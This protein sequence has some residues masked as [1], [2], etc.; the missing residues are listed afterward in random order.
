MLF[1][2]SSFC[3]EPEFTFCI[4]WRC[5]GFRG[6]AI[7]APPPPP[8]LDWLCFNA[9][10]PRNGA[11]ALFRLSVRPSVWEFRYRQKSQEPLVD[12]YHT[13]PKDAPWRVDELN[14]FGQDPLKVKVNELGLNMLFYLVTVISG[15]LLGGF[16]SYLAQMCTMMSRWTD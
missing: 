7:G 1:H 6:G 9:S 12:F 4:E 10:D 2:V 13:W 11:G 16:L 5:G 14:R 15:K 8:Q 3:N